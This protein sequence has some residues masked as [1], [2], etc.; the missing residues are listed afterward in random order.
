MKRTAKKEDHAEDRKTSEIESGL[1][2]TYRTDRTMSI[3]RAETH[4]A[5]WPR[6]KTGIKGKHRSLNLSPYVNP[7]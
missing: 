4:C 5:K 1:F 6:N 3:H 2:Y 7:A